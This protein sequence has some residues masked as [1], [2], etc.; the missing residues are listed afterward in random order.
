MNKKEFKPPFTIICPDEVA[1][2]LLISEFVND[3]K[4]IRGFKYIYD[5]QTLVDGINIIIEKWE[6]KLK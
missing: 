1:K 5:D 4:T 2:N 6:E 3:L